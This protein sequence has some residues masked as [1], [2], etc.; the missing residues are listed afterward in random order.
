MTFR[1]IKDI[2]LLDTEFDL[3]LT[4]ILILIYNT[5][6]QGKNS[7][8]GITKL[9]KMDFLLRYPKAL[10]RGLKFIGHTDYIL[11]I[12][13]YEKYNVE[14]KMIRFKY[15]PWD[16]RYRTFLLLLQSRGL[17]DLEIIN[18]ATHIKVTESGKTLAERIRLLSEFRDYDIRSMIIKRNFEHLSASE[19][20]EFM[21]RIIPELSE[22]NLGDEIRI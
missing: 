5:T 15:G 6:S 22:L 11:E 8:R 14:S 4:R 17:L 21:Y 3:H 18:N 13:E 16:P 10:E 7:I 19:I 20:K 12:K 1:L 2:S 9:V